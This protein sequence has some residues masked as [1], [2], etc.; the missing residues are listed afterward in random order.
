MIRYLLLTVLALPFAAQAQEAVPLAE[1]VSRTHIH[2]IVAGLNGL[3]S[4]TLATHHGVFMV[5]LAEQTAVPVG[6]SRDD[7]MGFSPVPGQFGHAFASGHPETGGNLGVIRTKDGGKTWAHVSDGIGG[8]VDFHNMEVSRADA[9]VLYG[10]SHDGTVQRSG[11]AGAS[12]AFTGTAPDKLIDIATSATAADQ[13]YAATENGL[14]E[15]RDAGASWQSILASTAPVSTVDMGTDG[16]LRAVQLG[17]GLIDVDVAS[18]DATIVAPEVPGGYLLNLSVTHADPLRLMALS[19]EG[20][21]LLSD[22]GGITW[23]A[24]LG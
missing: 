24:V 4:A 3:D 12:W 19:P 1:L 8:P 6:S 17:Q 9:A 11:D 13:I 5:D 22:D 21:L 15:S 18:G 14:F 20:V 2:G 23:R 16:R 10:I 7:F